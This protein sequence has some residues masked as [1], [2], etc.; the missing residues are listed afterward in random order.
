MTKAELMIYLDRM[1]DGEEVIVWDNGDRRKIT[2]VRLDSASAIP[3]DGKMV[4]L[5][6]HLNWRNPLLY[7]RQNG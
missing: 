2:D 3:S 4:E 7:P 5:A 1:E 6:I